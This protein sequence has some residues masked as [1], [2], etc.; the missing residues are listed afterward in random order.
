MIL[1]CVFL[2]LSI[3]NSAFAELEYHFDAT[4]FKLQAI[5]KII[6]MDLD[7]Q[8]DLAGQVTLELQGFQ[9]DY[10]QLVCRYEDK[11]QQINEKSFGFSPQSR[12]WAAHHCADH[13]SKQVLGYDL[14]YAARIAYVTA[15]NPNVV[16]QTDVHFANT[17]LLF[18]AVG[19]VTAMAW[20]AKAQRLAYVVKVDDQYR[21][22]IYDRRTREHQLVHRV[23]APIYAPSWSDEKT[24]YFSQFVHE[25]PKIMMWHGQKV[26]QVTYGKDLDLMPYTYKGALYYL[27]DHTGPTAVYVKR[28]NGESQQLTH[29][30]HAIASFQISQGILYYIVENGTQRYDLQSL[31]LK[32]KHGD[33]IL[34]DLD[35]TAFTVS[36]MGIILGQDQ[37]IKMYGFNGKRIRIAPKNVTWVTISGKE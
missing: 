28:P 19:P 20:S 1:R 23:Q 36:P 21:L 4:D 32:D 15:E 27:S 31:D 3:L 29:E 10:K 2:I 26:Q 16:M 6:A 25:L 12:V 24:L 14:G 37:Q 5:Q 11:A 34:S 30:E 22:M 9:N 18:E 13:I 35:V 8:T 7:S 17:T 33:T